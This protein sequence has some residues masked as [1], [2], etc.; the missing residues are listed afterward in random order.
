[1]NDKQK[2]QVP[3]FVYAKTF[4]KTI[5]EPHRR[6]ATACRAPGLIWHFGFWP[7]REKDPQDAKTQGDFNNRLTNWIDAELA[8][9][10]GRLHAAGSTGYPGN[11]PNFKVR[12]R[13]E[14]GVT[15]KIYTSNRTD[16]E[17]RLPWN[18]FNIG[19]RIELHADYVT[20][21]FFTSVEDASDA[22][23]FK[24]EVIRWFE[25]ASGADAEDARAASDYLHDGFWRGFSA[26]LLAK[27]GGQPAPADEKQAAPGK[28]LQRLLKWRAKKPPKPN[29]IGA[30][31]P[32]EIFLDVR[33]VLLQVAETNDG[34]IPWLRSMGTAEAL[35]NSKLD[36]KIAAR[37]LK[38][39]EHFLSHG[40]FDTDPREYVA[41]L[42]LEERALFISNLGSEP[43]RGEPG[44]KDR[45]IRYQVFV[46]QAKSR[47]LG[48]L[49]ERINTLETL[50]IMSLKDV[51]LI[52]EVGTSIRL[53]GSKLDKISAK[54]NNV[55]AEKPKGAR[56]LERALCE[57]EARLD[58]MSGLPTGGLAYR[59]VRS[60]YYGDQFKR[61]LKT[62]EAKPLEFWQS[63]AMFAERR[64]YSV[65]DYIANTGRRI[66]N[67]RNRLAATLEA[68]QTTILVDLTRSVH[69]VQ[70]STQLQAALLFVIG[71]STFFGELLEPVYK[72]GRDNRELFEV[73]TSS[74]AWALSY[75]PGD[76][77]QRIRATYEEL[78][79]EC[80]PTKAALQSMN[81]ILGDLAKQLAADKTAN[82]EK[83]QAFFKVI[84]Y[85]YGLA[86][87]LAFL[88]VIF[89]R[90]I[91]SG[92]WG[93]F[94]DLRSLFGLK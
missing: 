8:P 44:N 54:L 59:V 55:R 24:S 73:M 27:G 46:K 30:F 4:E 16:V 12:D 63:Y 88:A 57:L 33:G 89:I 61:R 76:I 39:H 6:S 48:R 13:D 9:F 17:F 64:Y 87:S 67:L 62:M 32:G 45:F 22:T 50:K 78:N 74:I 91:V 20:V 56:K 68:I 23:S 52:R 51:E 83:C 7:K 66:R 49:V 71:F 3:A 31:A 93:I 72:F 42:F 35:A 10:V 69:R 43:P 5:R 37:L 81:A 2:P 11:P 60:D 28:W 26:H 94:L 40:G 84:G 65:L 19:A 29:N 14:D 53:Q 21:T 92:L 36:G 80:L 85:V 38:Q 79:K 34:F 58:E 75:L 18:G 41:N 25:N 1:M 15:K 77:D 70:A 86:G 90:S 47:E 82:D